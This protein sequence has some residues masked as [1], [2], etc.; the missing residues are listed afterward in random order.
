MAKD[1]NVGPAGTDNILGKDTRAALLKYQ[2]DNN[3]PQGNLNV[4]TMKHLGTKGY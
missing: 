3:L 1:Y 4:E 2:K